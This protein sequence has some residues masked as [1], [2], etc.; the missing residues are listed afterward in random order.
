MH[1]E[2]GEGSPAWMLPWP[3]RSHRSIQVGVRR[4]FGRS[5]GSRDLLRLEERL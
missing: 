4:V 5:P 2:K 3:D 1:D